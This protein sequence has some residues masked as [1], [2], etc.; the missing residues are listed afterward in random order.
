MQGPVVLNSKEA[1]RKRESQ[2]KRCDFVLV[3]WWSPI[4]NICY[5]LFFTQPSENT[6]CTCT[7]LVLV[8]CAVNMWN[9][10]LQKFCTIDSVGTIL[11]KNTHQLCIYIGEDKSQTLHM[12]CLKQS[13][14]KPFLS[15]LI[16]TLHLGPI[17]SERVSECPGGLILSE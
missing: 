13:W 3:S 5:S 6:S 11:T 10:E 17:G 1:P 8:E 12:P 15:F 7:D 9:I 4:G 16:L 14:A 2:R